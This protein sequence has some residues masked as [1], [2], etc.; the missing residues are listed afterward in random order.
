MNSDKTENCSNAKW[1]D[2]IGSFNH[3]DDGVVVF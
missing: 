1:D 3:R 2:H